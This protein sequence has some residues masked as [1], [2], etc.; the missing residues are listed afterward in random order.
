M[1]ELSMFFL[2]WQK[3]ASIEKKETQSLLLHPVCHMMLV[4][5]EAPEGEYT[6]VHKQTHDSGIVYT[7]RLLVIY[8]YFK[9]LVLCFSILISVIP[10]PTLKTPLNR[11][12]E[13]TQKNDS[14][15]DRT[16]LPE[17]VQSVETQLLPES[18]SR[19]GEKKD[20]STNQHK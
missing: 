4:V 12:K 15:A 8:G 9:V 20:G 14:F 17:S 3:C 1:S 5:H 13:S 18:H 2:M 6:L 19:D 16:T 10:N 7:S 11:Q